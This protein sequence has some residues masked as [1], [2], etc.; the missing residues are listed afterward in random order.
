M[1]NHPLFK[2]LSEY[3][4]KIATN[5]FKKNFYKKGEFIVKEGEKFSKAFILISG[6]VA[7][8]KETIYKG[9]YILSKVKS[10]GKEFFA[11][12]N[13]IDKGFV[14]TTIKCLE[15]CEILEIEHSEFKKL[16][17]EYPRIGVE[18]LWK[19]ASDIAKHLRKS[20]EDVL[21]LLDSLI[22]VLERKR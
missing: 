11:E 14:T 3:E 4:Y 20:D 6:E 22:E 9:D 13:L 16:C 12:I 21:S 19:I 8:I 18:F 7:I 10:G 2:N 5:F 15:D 17:L 1:K